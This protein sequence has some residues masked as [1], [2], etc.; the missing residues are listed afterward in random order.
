[1][2]L[3]YRIEVTLR[4]TTQSARQ[5]TRFKQVRR[6]DTHK[7]NGLSLETLSIVILYGTL[8]PST[9][10]YIQSFTMTF[11][12]LYIGMPP[13]HLYVIAT[14]ENSY[15]WYSQRMLIINNSTLDKRLKIIKSDWN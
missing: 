14:A 1:M 15:I 7:P 9:D 2:F 12:V 3:L 4:K 6:L 5:G 8:R 10:L 11:T 13:C